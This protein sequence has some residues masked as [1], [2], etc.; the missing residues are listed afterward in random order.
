MGTI[1]LKRQWRFVGPVVVLL[2]L[3]GALWLL[4]REIRHF[5]FA[6]V[7]EAIHSIPASHLAAAIG[8]TVL[9]YLVLIGYDLLN[10]RS[11]GHSFSAKKIA[12]ASLISYM[13]SNTLG[14]LLGGTSVRYRIYSTWGLKGFEVVEL[15]AL[16]GLTF[17]LGVFAL[18]GVL[19][20]AA[21]FPVPERLQEYVHLDN[22]VPIG[23]GLL[24]LVGGY[25]AASAVWRRPI[26]IF[27]WRTQLPPLRISLCQIAISST[28]ITV[29]G[30]VV[31]RP[32]PVG[33]RVGFL[34]FWACIFW[35]SWR[36]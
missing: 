10:I 23:V 19:F 12:L 16:L 13:V 3:F 33:F 24:G 31:L 11:L 25:L 28:D 9:N 30:G 8:L 34:R 2:I 36:R 26:E 17:W 21:P 7:A 29:A 6:K 1:L 14:M 35:P 18:A 5:D 22:V 27:R 20:V 4:Y 15:V 32:A